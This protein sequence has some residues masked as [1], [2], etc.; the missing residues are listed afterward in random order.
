MSPHCHLVKG[1]GEGVAL[2]PEGWTIL[3][4][5]LQCR[6]RVFK[7]DRVPS[8]RLKRRA[9]EG[10]HPQAT[11]HGHGAPIPPPP[12]RPPHRW[13]PLGPAH[14]HPDGGSNGGFTPYGKLLAL[15]RHLYQASRR[16]AG[17]GGTGSRD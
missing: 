12:R 14:F 2:V 8:G 1:H 7:R 9:P 13:H 11:G 4:R 3:A 5:P 10:A 17:R 15:I 6:V 16:D